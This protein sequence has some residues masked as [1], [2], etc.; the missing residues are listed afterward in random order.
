MMLSFNEYQDPGSQFYNRYRIYHKYWDKQ[1][2]ATSVEPCHRLQNAAFDQG[3][4]YLP[5]I[6]L[7]D[8]NQQVVFMNWFKF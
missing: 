1:A 5:F 4:H 8:S 2:G 7:F 6:Q 3:L